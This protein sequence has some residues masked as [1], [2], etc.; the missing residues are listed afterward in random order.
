MAA[1]A[2][3]PRGP[4]ASPSGHRASILLRPSGAGGARKAGD[5]AV[6]LKRAEGG[7]SITGV[8]EDRAG[9]RLAVPRGRG[10]TKSRRARNQ[11]RVIR[12]STRDLGATPRPQVAFRRT[13]GASK[14]RPVLISPV[15][16]AST[17]RDKGSTRGGRLV[18]P[19][20][21]VPITRP[22]RGFS[23]LHE[24]H[25]GA[26]VFRNICTTPCPVVVYSA[27]LLEVHA[28]PLLQE[29]LPASP[30]QKW[31]GQVKWPRYHQ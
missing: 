25:L 8:N 13:E 22:T 27:R 12:V 7:A 18:K 9:I 4:T 10:A 20:Q 1:V 14:G 11:G 29:V 2:R 3:G 15:F 5:G 16:R 19:T 23:A 26:N 28:R 30:P 6:T 24:A 31:L 21:A 17:A